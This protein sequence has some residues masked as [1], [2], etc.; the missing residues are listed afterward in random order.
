M[1]YRFVP[2]LKSLNA[3]YLRGIQFGNVCVLKVGFD[4]SQ[5]LF[6]IALCSGKVALQDGI[7]HCQTSAFS[8]STS[9]TGNNSEQSLRSTK[10][11]CQ[12]TNIVKYT[13]IQ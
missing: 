6:R 7:G 2:L 3:I 4:G 13:V 10:T 11:H 1:S 9:S 8:G 5:G 12:N